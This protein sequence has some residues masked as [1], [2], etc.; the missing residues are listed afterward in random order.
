MF[1]MHTPSDIRLKEDIH[2]KDSNQA[3]ENI[4]KL[5]VVNYSYKPEIAERWGLT[6]DQRKKTG[7]IAQELA[8]VLPDAVHDIGD[9]LAVDENRLFYETILATKELCRLH[10]T[11]ENKMDD[12]VEEISQRITRYA[13]RKKL[14]G[15]MASNLSGDTTADGKS[16]LSLSRT[17][18]ASGYGGNKKEKREVTT[19][20]YK[21]Q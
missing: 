6:E 20:K 17:T 18:L 9:Y 13:R 11:L 14:L 3:L 8:A 16:V 1:Q 21:N 2:P 15:S 12:K 5:N 10:G 4:L 19:N 7:L